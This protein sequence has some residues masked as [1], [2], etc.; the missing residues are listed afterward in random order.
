[1]AEVKI[2]GRKLRVSQGRK[3]KTDRKHPGASEKFKKNWADPV[4][5]DKQL[6]LIRAGVAKRKAEG[7]TKTRIG[8]PDGMRKEEAA[9]AWEKAR[10][11]GKRFIKIMEDKELVEKV[12]VPGTPEEMA[13]RALEEA[14]VFAVGPHTS[15]KE[16]V[17]YIRTV[18]EWTKAKPESA[19]KLTV[20]KAED[21]LAELA[22]DM[23]K[24]DDDTSAAD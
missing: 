13:K 9:V 2:D 1:M 15:I 10:D 12:V 16:K 19:S 21:W 4:W 22:A 23:P 6:A 20:T 5:R 7:T 11:L 24:K 17:S 18:L 3:K 14:F 8:V